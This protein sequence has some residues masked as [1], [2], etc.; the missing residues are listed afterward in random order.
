M[1]V[2]ALIALVMVI[3]FVIY[4]VYAIIHRFM[5]IHIL[6]GIVD[7]VRFLSRKE[8]REHARKLLAREQAEYD[9]KVT[10]RAI[11]LIKQQTDIT[12]PE[13]YSK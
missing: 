6:E 3:A 9:A 5:L 13:R 12:L 4:A 1:R 2:L 10:E 11:E 8:R 7:P